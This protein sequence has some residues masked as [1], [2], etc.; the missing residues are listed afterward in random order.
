MPFMDQQEWTYE[1]HGP[2]SGPEVHE[3]P[4]SSRTITVDTVEAVRP[5]GVTIVGR[6]RGYGLDSVTKRAIRHVRALIRQFDDDWDPTEVHVTP[7]EQ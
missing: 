3:L 1:I 5:G 6:T 4:H 7:R 2:L